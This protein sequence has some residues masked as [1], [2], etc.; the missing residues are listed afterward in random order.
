MFSLL[1]PM[2]PDPI[3]SITTKFQADPRSEK[4][5]LGV[6]VYRDENGNTPIPAAVRKAERQIIDAQT[7]KTY[8]A[9]SG[10]PAFNDEMSK[11]ILGD[12][13]V[14]DRTF[15]VQTP[16]GTGALRNLFDLVHVAT[17]DATVWLSDPTWANHK[18]VANGAGLQTVTYPYY[19]YATGQIVFDRMLTGLNSVK[20]GDIV[21][22]HGCCHNPTGADLDLDQWRAVAEHLRERGALP[23]VDIAYM[24]LGDGLEADAAGLRLLASLSE[25]VMIA[26][27][28]SKNFGL[29]RDRVGAAIVQVASAKDR[30]AGLDNAAFV[31]RAAY[32]MPP[33]MGA[34]TVARILETDELRDSWTGELEEMRI[35]VTD[36]R[37]QLAAALRLKLNDGRFDFLADQKGMFSLLGIDAAQVESL[38]RDHGVYMPASGRI[39]MAGL[40]ASGIDPVASAIAAVCR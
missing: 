15:A 17:P 11:L 19:D 16:G 13:L 18:A 22:L 32:S 28:C 40:S 6:G 38:A 36:L 26:A 30:Q 14:A 2:P 25:E 10:N 39:N 33:D 27:S 8:L 20:A 35:R 23:L 4:F 34:A 9:P 29:Y 21:V 24:G 3:L 5:D 12:S 1:S 7:T 37:N 31:N